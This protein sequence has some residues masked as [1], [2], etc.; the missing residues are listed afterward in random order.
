M[1]QMYEIFVDF[2]DFFPKMASLVY[3][4]SKKLFCLF[5]CWK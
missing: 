1:I 2:K 5:S 4:S 3:L